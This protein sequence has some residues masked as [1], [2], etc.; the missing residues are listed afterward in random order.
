[1]ADA[2][3]EQQVAVRHDPVEQRCLLRFAAVRIVHLFR[4]LLALRGCRRRNRCCCEGCGRGHATTDERAS[5]RCLHIRTPVAAV[6]T[7]TPLMIAT[8]ARKH[9]TF[10]LREFRVFAFSWQSDRCHELAT[11]P[12]FM[13]RT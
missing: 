9:E 11:L 2:G 7:S 1:M 6:A 8:K 5:I 10:W 3:D 4:R 13:F 12:A